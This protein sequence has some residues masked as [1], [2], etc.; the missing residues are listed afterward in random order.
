MSSWTGAV[1]AELPE[2]AGDALFL[3]RLFNLCLIFLGEILGVFTEE[4][5]KFLNYA[6]YLVCFACWIGVQIMF[7]PLLK[8]APKLGEC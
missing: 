3:K 1:S 4:N 8:P 2:P 5:K 7:D 6:I